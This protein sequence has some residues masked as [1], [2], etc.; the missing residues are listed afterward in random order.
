MGAL[1]L[2]SVFPGPARGGYIDGEVV[3][4]AVVP[5]G[6]AA[7]QMR[8]LPRGIIDRRTDI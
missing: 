6:G 5:D 2:G 1:N 7:E 3:D 8:T 4:G